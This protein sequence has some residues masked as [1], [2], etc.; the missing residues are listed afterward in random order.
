VVL[1]CEKARVGVAQAL[2]IVRMQ[3]VHR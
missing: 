1:P 2:F 3:R